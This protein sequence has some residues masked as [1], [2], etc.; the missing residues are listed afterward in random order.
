M[1]LREREWRLLLLGGLAPR[2]REAPVV[3]CGC[4]DAD[5]LL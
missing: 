4:L 3:P 1:A 2:M 5:F